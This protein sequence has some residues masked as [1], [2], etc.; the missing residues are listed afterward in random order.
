M[1]RMHA[2]GS[3][4][5]VVRPVP[6]D[7]VWPMAMSL[8]LDLDLDDFRP[9]FDEL[10]DAMLVWLDD[11]ALERATDQA[12]DAVWDDG[13]A[14]EVRRALVELTA[15]DT[16]CR[17]EA[18]LAL[19]DF[20][21]HGRRSEMARAAAQVMGMQLSHDDIPP[22]FCLCCVD[23]AIGAAPDADERRM[24]A[25]SVAIVARRDV[26]LREEE[27][28]AALRQNAAQPR[29]V[30]VSLATPARRSAMRARLERIGRLS[31]ESLS[32]LSRELQTMLASD[33][34]DDPAEDQLWLRLC[35]AALA[36][37]AA[38]ELN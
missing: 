27:L 11:P 10:A 18:R 24:L 2:S 12:L 20:D 7:A 26:R 22:L 29:R 3:I 36:D 34:P 14:S 13:L 5:F 23:E 8:P 1:T 38:P 19:E 15:T 4:Q 31:S 6:P 21:R 37:V 35:E 9:A 17:R 16:W 33:P 30:A 25:A 28:L 32:E